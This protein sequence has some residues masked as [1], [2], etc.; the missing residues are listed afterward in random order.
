MPF[1]T[2]VAEAGFVCQLRGLTVMLL[3]AK[4]VWEPA[5]ASTRTVP[6]VTIVPDQMEL[7]VPDVRLTVVEPEVNRQAEIVAPPVTVAVH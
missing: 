5:C 6:L 7:P 2:F 1:G 4:R 3:E